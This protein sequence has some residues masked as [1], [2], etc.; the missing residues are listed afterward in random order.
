MPSNEELLTLARTV[1]KELEH[2]GSS[3]QFIACVH[4]TPNDGI[5]HVFVTSGEFHPRRNP[6]SAS[7]QY[8]RY[9]LPLG[10]LAEST[11]GQ[12]AIVSVEETVGRDTRTGHVF[13]DEYFIRCKDI[14]RVSNEAEQ[15]DAINN[16]ISFPDST[17]FIRTLR[18]WLVLAAE[19]MAARAARPIR[20]RVANRF[21]LSDIPVVDRSQGDIWRLDIRKFIVIAG[22]PGTGKT[23]TAIKRIAQKTDAAALIEGNEVTQFPA[24]A[25]RN[26]LKGRAGWALFTP[27]ELLRGYLREALAQEG[28]AATEDQVPVWATTKVRIARDALRF[29]GQD[30]FLSLSQDLVAARDSA[31][32]ARWTKSFVAHFNARIQSEL[33]QA[34]SEQSELLR[35]TLERINQKRT[36]L[37][38]EIE[39][40]RHELEKLQE[41]DKKATTDQERDKIRHR[42]HDAETKIDPLTASLKPLEAVAGIQRDLVAIVNSATSGT[43]GQ[44]LSSF[45]SLRDRL[46]DFL[47]RVPESSWPETESAALHTVV[48][49]TRGL[50]TKFVDGSGDSVD[51]TLRRIPI[52]YQ[53]YRLRSSETSGFYRAA[54]AGAVNDKRVDPLELD[55]L[56]YT[57]L[58]TLRESFAGREIFQRTGNSMTQRLINEFRYVIAVDEATDFSAVEL[59]CMKL[60]A[61]PL[62]DCATFAGD[63]MQRMTSQGIGDWKEISELAPS[64]EMH[65][66]KL[67]YRQ[68]RK[69]LRI[70]A[71]LFEKSIGQPAPFSAGYGEKPDDP[72]ALWYQNQ[73]SQDQSRWIT[74]RIGEVYRI[75]D[76]T[77]PSVAVLV[78]EEADVR[79]V[80][81]LLRE[82]LLEAYGIETEACLEGRILGTQAKVRV[83]SVQFIKGL[84]FEAVFFLGAD[85]MAALSPDLIHRYLYVGLTRARSFLA[86][87]THAEFPQAL[88]HVREFFKQGTWEHLLPP[89]SSTET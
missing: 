28:L 49:A 42:T 23:T 73:S 2:F 14:F 36:Q 87:T 29:I 41:E 62:F 78:A 43:L 57:A 53:E 47:H 89:T 39:P 88:S 30:R 38:R 79:S 40:V 72:D 20:R 68:S 84:E 24:E 70:A 37:L 18:E 65:E 11:P 77:L 48:A 71:R 25:L 6:S 15:I 5:E 33:A 10:R 45:L 12:I 82:P 64:P 83:F 26:W 46:H 35:E 3:A 50:I 75:C 13:V 16:D 59:A 31:S 1:I 54:A 76:Q 51:P 74:E 32:L 60:L 85:R 67:S 63:L 27:S 21:E 58:T 86:L 4:V 52:V 81:D 69:L 80:A 55:S 19:E 61:H 34:F 8:V 22:A 66:L 9:R 44:T 17:T 7:I 56:I